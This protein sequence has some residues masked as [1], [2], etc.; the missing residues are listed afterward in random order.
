MSA[1][2]SGNA[3]VHVLQLICDTSGTAAVFISLCIQF[4][5]GTNVSLLLSL[6]V[7]INSQ[8]WSVEHSVAQTK[9]Y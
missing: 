9:L 5:Y 2:I 4:D 8:K 7:K 3:R 1:D 6:F